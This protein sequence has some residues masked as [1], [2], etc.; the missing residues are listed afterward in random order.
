MRSKSIADSPSDGFLGTAGAEGYPN[1]W[2]SAGEGS[3]GI[4]GVASSSNQPVTPVVAN[5]S[6]T[7]VVVTSGGMTFDLLFD[8]AAMAAPASFR[9]GIEPAA[10][11]LPV[12]ITGFMKAIRRSGPT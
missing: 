4:S 1:Y 7:L 3:F 12:P 9:A 8:A 2:L 6:P 10:A 5:A 11:L